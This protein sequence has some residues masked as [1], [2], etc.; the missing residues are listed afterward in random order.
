MS[1]ANSLTD[2][3]KG[4]IATYSG[5]IIN[6]LDPD[7]AEIAI[8]DIAHALSNQCRFTGHVRKFYS[9][10]EHSVR[11]VH[12]LINRDFYLAEYP[13]PQVEWDLL[14][15]A[16]LHDASEAYLSDIARPVKQGLGLGDTYR[17]AEEKLMMVIAEK[18]HMP[19]PMPDM[20]A[21]VDDTLL[22]TEQRD[23]M[24][25]G[26]IPGDE[27]ADEKIE[28]TWTPTEARD[29]FLVLADELIV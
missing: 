7:P 4:Y 13:D 25:A 24:P 9:V 27:Y 11:C 12:E 10:A 18:Y 19:W 6:P 8:E 21:R 15:W 1:E 3:P 16:L 14:R 23:L 5:R 28:E 26:R 17:E 20:I 2:L 22:R 29:K